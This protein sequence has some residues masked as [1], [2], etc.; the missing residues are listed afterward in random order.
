MAWFTPISQTKIIVPQRR[1]ELLSRPRLLALLDDLL[2]FKLIIIAAPE[3]GKT[4]DDRLRTSYDWLLLIA[5]DP[6]YQN[7]RI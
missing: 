3:Y 2:D 7:L 6:L 1:K 4:Y 5:L